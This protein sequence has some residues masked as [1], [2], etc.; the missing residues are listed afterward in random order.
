MR[1]GVRF[2]NGNEFNADDVLFSVKR[3]GTKGSRQT[4]WAAKVKVAKIDDLT[5]EFVTKYPDSIFL[6]RLTQ[7][8]I[9]DK[10]SSEERGASSPSRSGYADNN[11]VGTGSYKFVKRERGDSIILDP[12]RG[13]WGKADPHGIT[14]FVYRRIREP[15]ARV[16][17]LLSGEA[18]IVSDVPPRDLSAVS[19]LENMDVI[20]KAGSR[21]IFLG[22]DQSRDRLLSSNAGKNPFKDRRVREAI[23]RAVNID[24]IRSEVMGGNAT[25]AS[26]IVSPNLIKNLKRIAYDPEKSKALIAEAGYSNGFRVNM[27]CP[28]GVYHR[29]GAICHAVAGMLGR[30]GIKVKIFIRDR[31]PYFRKLRNREASFY[32]QGWRPP[33]SDA[34]WSLNYLVGSP[35]NKSFRGYANFGG[36]SN[37]KLD[38]LTEVIPFERVPEKRDRLIRDAIEIVA[39][40][41][42]VIPLHVQNVTFAKSSKIKLRL[43]QD[44]VLDL[45]YVSVNEKP[46]VESRKQLQVASRSSGSGGGGSGGSGGSGSG[47]GGGSG[48][49]GGGGGSSGGSGSSSSASGGGSGSGGGFGSGFGNIVGGIIGDN[50][51][52]ASRRFVPRHSIP[53]EFYAAYGIVAFPWR[54]GQDTRGRHFMIC[55]SYEEGLIK[56]SVLAAVVPIKNQM[57]TVWPVKKEEDARALNNERYEGVKVCSEAVARY[58]LFTAQQAIK[59]AETAGALINGPGPFLIAWAPS[60]DK[61][62]PDSVVLVMDLSYVSTPA[63]T[64]D[65]FSI[66]RKEIEKNNKLWEN[67][68]R[69]AYI[70][71]FLN[72]IGPKLSEHFSYG[73]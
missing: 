23:Y 58:D 19:K 2:H 61:G 1:R 42:A 40:D 22:M 50:A 11:A 70:R 33:I 65:A 32:L 10:E 38:R 52:K 5:V 37:P 29:D 34:F 27:D 39:A 30:I 54:A 14:K 62:K 57:V 4:T 7:F 18:D 24:E 36:Y 63:D 69:L 55:R 73:K 56:S 71:W 6:K 66:W 46:M 31:A 13:W 15:A 16:A 12:F 51:V 17:A 41:Y 59:D 26:T 20:S 72:S 49:S 9:M 3:A 53:P 44:A 68:F 47:G 28:N 35:D 45:R 60:K 67:G 43:R 21:V 64:A 48:G 25:P 8:Y